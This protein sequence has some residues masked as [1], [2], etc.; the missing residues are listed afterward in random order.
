MWVA[1]RRRRLPKSKLVEVLDGDYVTHRACPERGC[2]LVSGPI[3]GH[4]G[5]NYVSF[6]C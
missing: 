5:G 3:R 2:I 1:V 6:D 4:R